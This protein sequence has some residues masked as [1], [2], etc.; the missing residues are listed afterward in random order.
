MTVADSSGTVVY[1]KL[2]ND[3]AA[4]FTVGA[5]PEV[6]LDAV[7]LGTGNGAGNNSL[8][9]LPF[10]QFDVLYDVRAGTIGVAAGQ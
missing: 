4:T 9:I 10:F 5:T 7:T 6:G 1:E 3:G 2:V 8:G